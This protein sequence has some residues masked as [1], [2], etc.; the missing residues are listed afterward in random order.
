[1]IMAFD[2]KAIIVSAKLY[3]ANSQLKMAIVLSLPPL[4]FPFTRMMLSMS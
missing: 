3:P 4:P 2:E 1:M